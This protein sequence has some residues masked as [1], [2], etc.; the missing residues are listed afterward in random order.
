MEAL[1]DEKPGWMPELR[2]WGPVTELPS[3][4][5]WCCG[6]EGQP[7]LN[8]HFEYDGRWQCMRHPEGPVLWRIPAPKEDAHVLVWEPR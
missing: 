3:T 1:I 4:D 6:Q 2:F 5:C 8:A 7:T